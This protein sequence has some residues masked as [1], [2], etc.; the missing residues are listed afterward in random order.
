MVNAGELCCCNGYIFSASPEESVNL[1]GNFILGIT[2]ISLDTLVA[3]II[4]THPRH[5]WRQSTSMSCAVIDL[6]E[7]TVFSTWSVAYCH[8]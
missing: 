2:W 5:Y 4:S 8:L 1:S 7:E 6:V 3:V